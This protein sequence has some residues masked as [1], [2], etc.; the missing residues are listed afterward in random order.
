MTH[1]T[2]FQAHRDQL[3]LDR[4]HLTHPL[5][6]GGM[7]EVW[8]ARDR[9]LDIEI[10]VKLL[11]PE[12]AS[13]PAQ[14]DFLKNECRLARRL[15]HPHIIA[16]YDFHHDQDIVF[17]SMAWVDGPSFDRWQQ[18]QRSSE[19]AL[20]LL[21]P[22][23][24]ALDYVHQQ[25]LVHRDIK[26]GNIL[27]DRNDIPLLTDFGI[28]GVFRIDA[29]PSRRY[30]GGSQDCMSPQQRRGLPPHPADDIY[31]FGV[32]LLE[33]LTQSQRVADDALTDDAI[34]EFCGEWAARLPGIT[35]L[36]PA[37]LAPRREDRPPQPGGGRLRAR[38][39]ANGRGPPNHA[40]SSHAVGNGGKGP[41]G[42]C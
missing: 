36:L 34:R 41:Y 40:S 25:G 11:H 42:I 14:V 17:I 4:F 38:A 35:D 32:L 29:D 22:I 39:G 31:S 26:S 3:L 5:G 8:R 21:V 20:R 37:M 27:V 23:A 28:A 19:E 24:R 12:L 9:D 6:Q 2:P 1:S 16:V 15:T 10:A 13:S 33:T 30:T 18:Q 7:G